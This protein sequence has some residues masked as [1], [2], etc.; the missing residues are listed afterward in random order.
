MKQV[1]YLY[2]FKREFLKFSLE[3]RADFAYLIEKYLNG[4]RLSGTQFKTFVIEKNIKVQEFKVKNQEGSWRAVSFIL[5]RDKLVF[6]YA[7]H[8][9][10]QELLLKDKKIIVK[11]VKEV[12]NE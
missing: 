4:D 7:F 11:R 12:Q 6:V 9:K 5:K 2:Q 1:V 10:S 3:T 8:K